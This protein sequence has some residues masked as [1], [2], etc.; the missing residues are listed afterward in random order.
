MSSY[1]VSIFRWVMIILL[2]IFGGCGDTW[3]NGAKSNNPDGKMQ[4]NLG[5]ESNQL[6]VAFSNNTSSP[7]KIWGQNSFEGWDAVSFK[8]RSESQ[9]SIQSIKRKNRDWTG[10]G[11]SILTIAPGDSHLAF[12]NLK[13][14]WWDI[15][16]DIYGLNNESLLVQATFNSPPSPEA[17]ENGVY[18]G[19]LESEWISSE[20]PHRWLFSN[21]QLEL[22]LSIDSGQLEITLANVSEKALHLWELD[23][24]WGWETLSFKLK[25]GGNEYTIRRQAKYSEQEATLFKLPPGE[26]RAIS[27]SLGE[28]WWILGHLP[29]G[30]RGSP[31]EI[32]ARLDIPV[33]P[34]TEANKAF[35]GWVRSEWVR[36]VP[37]HTW[38]P[39]NN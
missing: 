32:Q 5:I 26:S 22:G 4:I 6:K 16:E 12:F 30:M 10:E 2:F 25:S 38:L 24:P 18:T 33:Y 29:Q 20:P 31:L 36:S 9:D 27:V 15:A 13:D 11:G 35:Y 37:P 39:D 34:E 1:C 8:I 17:R 21:H 19:V 7:K 28:K 3:T 14:G 23:N